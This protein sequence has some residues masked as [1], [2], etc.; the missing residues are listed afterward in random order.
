MARR[1]TQADWGLRFR[2]LFTMAL[3]A[4]LYLGFLSYLSS[5]G[6]SFGP[7]IAIAALMLGLQ[8]FFSHKLAMWGM[9]AKE[10]TPEEAPELHAMVER[11][12]RDAGI[13]KPKVAISKMPIPN[14]FA[15]GR[16][17]KH[18]VVAVTEGLLQR[19]EP[20]EVE[21]VIGHEIFHV[22]NRDVAVMTLASFF[23]MIAFFMM[24]MFFFTGLFGGGRRSNDQG[25][26]SIWMVYLVSMLV[27]FVSQI[28]ILALGRYREL[29]ADRGGAHLTR[30][31]KD[32][33]SAL[34]K[35]SGDMAHT[36]PEA[37]RQVESMN[38]F[39]IV[40]TS[41]KE[42]FSSHPSLERRLDQLERISEEL[43]TS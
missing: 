20:H 30:K 3:L 16:S 23:A 29:A 4:A 25:G 8:Y 14:A 2:M 9:R 21:A 31:P 39:F 43:G 36:A 26:G 12:A 5:R 13:P 10:V 41:I 1:V 34:V 38:A 11:L 33:A 17:P 37:K 18:S 32:L 19:L 28:L 24:R 40:P 15:T 22:V 42:I 27:Y 6:V 35:I 7:L